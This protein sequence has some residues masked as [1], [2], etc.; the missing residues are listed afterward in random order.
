MQLTFTKG[1]GTS[2]YLHIERSTLPL[3]TI[4]CPKQGIIPHDMIHFAVES[5]VPYEGFLSLLLKCKPASFSMDGNEV[6]S[7]IE[8]LVETIQAEMWGGRVAATDLISMYEH[9]CRASGHA[10][11]PV[12]PAQI[13]IIRASIDELS[14]AWVS[15][16]LKGELTVI[17]KGACGHAK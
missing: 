5:T 10:V 14:A 13:E 2:D 16:P 6:A 4:E 15:I 3:E 7:A 11:A 1:T 9:G 8:R 17:F 12:S